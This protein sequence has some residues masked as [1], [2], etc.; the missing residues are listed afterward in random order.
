M[1]KKSTS[2]GSHPAMTQRI[3]L[4]I[5][6][7]IGCEAGSVRHAPSSHDFDE[8]SFRK[9]AIVHHSKFGRSTSESG[10][11]RRFRIGPGMSGA[12]SDFA[13]DDW[14]SLFG[15]SAGLSPACPRSGDVEYRVDAGGDGQG[16][17]GRDRSTT[18]TWPLPRHARDVYRWYRVADFAAFIPITGSVLCHYRHCSNARP[19]R[20][21]T[22][23]CELR[24]RQDPRPIAN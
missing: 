10:H 16:G 5:N 2:A 4:R 24:R 9:L 11:S 6:Q 22:V 18:G 23:S 20:R 17:S 15:A 21:S 12:I 1:A 13:G 8:N 14:P 19:V 3:G 7:H